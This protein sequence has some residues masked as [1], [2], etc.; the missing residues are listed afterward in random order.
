MAFF[1]KVEVS[2]I[3][4]QERRLEAL[5]NQMPE[6]KWFAYFE[7]GSRGVEALFEGQFNER[8]KS[9]NPCVLYCSEEQAYLSAGK[10]I[11]GQGYVLAF[12]YD[13]N[14]VRK[15]AKE[16]LFHTSIL[17]AFS[18]FEYKHNYMYPTDKKEIKIVENPHFLKP[19]LEARKSDSDSS[20]DP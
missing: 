16:G 12:G 9:H 3:E 15:L 4:D 10:L 1:K 6:D 14:G 13:R 5:H 8:Y 7:Y 11:P 2:S 17:Y 18:A 20:L 19:T